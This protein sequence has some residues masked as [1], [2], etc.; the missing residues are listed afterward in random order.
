MGVKKK[1][2][3]LDT[4]NAEKSVKSL[5]TELKALKDQ[6]LN[7]EQ[8]TEEYNHVLQQAADIQHELREQT[9][10]VAASAMDF[11]QIMGNVTSTVGGVVSGF[12]ALSASMSLLGIENEDAI[13]A[14]KKLQALMA[15]TQG[16]AGVENGIKAFKRLTTLISN[17]T[18]VTK[19][20]NK[21]TAG[22]AVAEKAAAAGAS[23]LT[24]SM[25]GEA[26]ATGAAT[27]A[28]HAFKTAL[29]STGIG[30]IVVLIG[31]LIAN[32]DKLTKAFSSSAKQAEENAR[33]LRNLQQEINS[34]NQS[35]D[36]YDA[37]LQKNEFTH[38]EEIH[39][40]D[41][42][43]ERMRA[44]G[45]S[46]AEIAAQMEKNNARKRQLAEEDIKNYDK[47]EKAIEDYFKKAKN[48][49]LS[50]INVY[51]NI[52]S[53]QKLIAKNEEI[54][55]KLRAGEKVSGYNKNS[56]EVLE[57]Q[58]KLL[59]Q[60]VEQMNKYAAIQKKEQAVNLQLADDENKLYNLRAANR[61][62][63]ADDAKKK[64]EE[65]RKAA[66]KEAEE[67]KKEAQK[68]AEDLKK[69]D[70]Q[71][72]VDIAE[73][74]EKELATIKKSETEKQEELKKFKSKGIINEAQYNE[75][76]N[77]LTAMY[78]KQRNEVEYKYAEEASKKRE[79]VLQQQYALEK[80]ALDRQ[81]IQQ[82]TA[83]EQER[84]NNL[85]ALNKREISIVEFYAREKEL[86][87]KSYDDERAILEADFKKQTDL[88]NA[89][90]DERYE[91][92]AQNGISEEQRNTI[93]QEIAEMTD[94]LL[95][96]DVEYNA[97]LV[98]MSTETNNAIADLNQSVIEQQIESL[99]ALTE[100]VVGAMDS[101]TGI[102][103]G[104]S[105]QWATA[106][107]TMSNGL[108][109]L[110]Q[111]IKEGG[112]QWQDYAQMAVAALSAAGSVMSAL[113]DEQETNTKE[114][115]EQ[116]KK[117]Q[118]AAVTMNMLGGVISAWTSA[119]NPANAW[120]T[121]FGQLAMGAAST[122]MILTTGLMQIQKIKQQQFNGGGGASASPSG[123]AISSINA[124][125]QYTQDV[126]GASIEGAIKDSKVYVVES[127][128]TNTQNKVNV[129]ENEA[130]Y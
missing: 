128:I 83:I 5:R 57:G 30:A 58:N 36:Y 2:V 88:I 127:D 122:A 95:T 42:L 108:I 77:K 11:G 84:Q 51:D 31:T 94:Q 54:L 89:Q 101:I 44:E 116:Q 1:V 99:R 120:M 113:A 26:A 28:T 90:I 15:L 68:L 27:V 103:E 61:K 63:A 49:N 66:Q 98:E 40:M 115:F 69:F 76:L 111:K 41:A 100:N 85:N 109:N 20:F 52:D 87:K 86:I 4:S 73:N 129:T 112:A 7:L 119:M 59:G 18:A 6:L 64:A 96:L 102:G 43:I 124:P 21:A 22:T 9:E 16:I 72:V 8:G 60:N 130:R 23:T 19:L 82:N 123:S 10:T 48:I 118:I 125:V 62:K 74:K 39:A 46:D 55:Q 114:G 126:Q 34:V 79:E 17:S 80:A 53:Y 121:I 67:R 14:I 104:I 38:Q 107:D 29:I 110:G 24:G 56:I 13:Q 12:Q 47:Q 50:M 91:L 78:D 97:A 3:E 65:R 105:S 75:R 81:Q 45:K 33:Q 71:L 93:T 106:F 92:L 35:V 25:T 32:L 37:Q 117:Y 70:A